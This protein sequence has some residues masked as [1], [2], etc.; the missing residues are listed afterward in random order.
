MRL[1]NGAIKKN[2][3]AEQLIENAGGGVGCAYFLQYGQGG[4]FSPVYPAIRLA[5]G[6]EQDAFDVR[7]AVIQGARLEAWLLGIEDCA[8][9]QSDGRLTDLS[10]IDAG[11][12]RLAQ[13]KFCCA[14]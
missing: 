3:V 10:F 12:T 2:F 8:I 1:F 11:F 14:P 13:W 6:V 7:I 9:N 5:H 4:I